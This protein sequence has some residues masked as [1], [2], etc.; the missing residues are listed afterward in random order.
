MKAVSLT[1]N[2]VERTYWVNDGDGG[3]FPCN[4]PG[5]ATKQVLEQLEPSVLTAIGELQP[6]QTI[7]VTVTIDTEPMK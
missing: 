2:K 5:L 1:I 4:G 6:G 7:K 3:T